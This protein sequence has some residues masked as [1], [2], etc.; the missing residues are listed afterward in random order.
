MTLRSV[1][2]FPPSAL[3]ASN[4][5]DELASIGN[6]RYDEPKSHRLTSKLFDSSGASLALVNIL[7]GIMYSM[8][9]GFLTSLD[10]SASSNWNQV[11]TVKCHENF[12]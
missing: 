7:F 8:T 10:I 6:K 4:F 2:E 1:G 5:Q 11:S 12:R 9:G 3:L